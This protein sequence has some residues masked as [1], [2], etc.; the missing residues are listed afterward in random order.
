MILYKVTN[1]IDTWWVIAEHP[2]QA[3]EKLY[4]L[5]DA[6]GY[7][8]YEHRKVLKI[9]LVATETNDKRFISGHFLIT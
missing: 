5:L 4:K 3:G 8:F 6:H 2:T 7:G 1:K 9:E